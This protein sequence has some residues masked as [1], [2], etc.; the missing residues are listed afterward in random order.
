[1]PKVTVVDDKQAR[2]GDCAEGQLRTSD[3]NGHCCWPDQ[4]WSTAKARCIGKPTC[5]GGMAIRG[6]ECV[7]VGR[8][9]AKVVPDAARLKPPAV[10]S[11]T[12]PSTTDPA[13]K[14]GAAKYA[15]GA[16]IEIKF[17]APV[18]APAA[19]RAW[20]TVVEASKPDTQYGS[21]SYVTDGATTMTL[22]APASPGSYEVRIHTDYPA[23][24]TNVRFR[25]PVTIEAA[26]DPAATPLAQQRFSLA[27]TR[28]APGAKATVKFPVA[29]R[30]NKGEQ[31]WVTIVNKGAAA[32]SY[33]SYAYVPADAREVELAVPTKPGEYEMRLHANYPKKTTNLV[34][35]VPF[36]VEGP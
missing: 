8:L 28:V 12:V 21:W 33:G 14:L 24:S 22:T 20:V 31:F 1:L 36:V 10:P 9:E 30:A 17:A 32:S 11:S 19:S 23:K 5:P 3:T 27:S 7:A 4:A 16:A 26:V 18:R 13:F 25:V 6:E 29:L 2:P 35:G 34:H 15:T